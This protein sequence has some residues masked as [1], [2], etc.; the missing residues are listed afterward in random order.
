MNIEISIA[1]ILALFVLSIII[2]PVG[3]VL[4]WRGYGFIGDSISHSC[5]FAAILSNMLSI[6]SIFGTLIMSM[7]MAITLV[8]FSRKYE[9]YI[10][11]SI[12]VSFLISISIIV[13]DIYNL[14]NFDYKDLFFGSI[15]NVMF[16]NIYLAVVIGIL[17][18]VLLYFFWKKILL[19]CFSKEIAQIQGIK[20]GIIDI[21]IIMFA[22]ISISILLKI[23]GA[24]LVISVLL[25]PAAAAKNISNTPTKMLMYSVVYS[26]VSCGLG[27]AMSILL[28]CNIQAS[29]VFMLC[30]TMIITY[31]L[32]RNI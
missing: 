20:T 25:T 30:T 10:S 2:A 1:S 9:G 23:V 31:F 12:V 16:E 19:S 4:T 13:R 28:K 18:Y 17:E 27:I 15:A 22:A 3:T 32:Y 24:I 11:S 14:G 6:S 29:I 7:I 21:I 26:I 5:L 8:S